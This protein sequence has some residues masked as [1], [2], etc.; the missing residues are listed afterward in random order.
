MKRI[1]LAIIVLLLFNCTKKEEKQEEFQPTIALKYI[2]KD[3]RVKKIIWDFRLN[4]IAIN[5]E[6]KQNKEYEAFRNNLNEKELIQLTECEVPL[7]RCI[8]FK[9]LV[10]KELIQLTECEVPLLRCIAFK[11]LVEK[12]YINIRKILNRH[13]NDNVLVKGYY[14]DVVRSEPVKNFMLNQ[15]SPFS[16]SKFKFSKKEFMKMQD[17][18]NKYN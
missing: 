8:A 15:L 13:K 11:T 2:I 16:S 7:L 10:E 6:Q 1:L 4:N 5:R 12:E 18:F 9:T 17:E 3:E 14:Y